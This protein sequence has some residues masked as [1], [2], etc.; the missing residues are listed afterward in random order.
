MACHRSASVWLAIGAACAAL[1]LPVAAAVPSFD[2]TNLVTSD[3]VNFPA[4]LTDSQLVNAW[5]V[6]YSPTSPF[7]VSDNGMGVS[8]IYRVDP[9]TQVPTKQGL[10]VSIPGD[11]SVTGQ[12]FN[13][14]STHS[15]GGN[16]FMFVSE[17]GTISGWQSGTN[18][19]V[20]QTA[21]TA[22]VYK[23]VALATTAAGNTYL[24]AANFRQGTIDVLKGNGGPDLTS[25]FTDPALPAGYAPFNIQ[26][27]NGSLYVSYAKQDA[28]GH[29]EIAGLG[30]G[31]V[32]Q[33]DLQGNL[34]ARIGTGG[35]L[36]APW[37]LA[38]AP[39]S[40]GDW[41]GALL[42]GN[43]GNGH[44]GAFD[45]TTHTF[46]G[47]VTGAGGQPLAIDGLWALMPGN[48]ATGGKAGS[49]DLIYAS[50]GPEDESA[51]LFAVLTPVPEPETGALLL[52]GLALMAGVL[53]RRRR[54][55]R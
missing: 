23:G 8:T 27:L 22:N 38:I 52:S 1:S 7:W 25:N 54:A 31:F 20:L 35:T 17:D 28:T 10:V 55:L 3:P 24:Y 34:V 48:S 43:F 42:V 41:A 40:F 45:P 29:D 11:G 26:L 49:S 12:V 51:G 37:G 13:S 47:E 21:A 50:A 2:V 14:D 53:H 15:F 18:A 36:D 33:Y 4:K 32:D 30:F 39:A 16:L 5:G 46:L 6:S 19:T 44:I 9:V